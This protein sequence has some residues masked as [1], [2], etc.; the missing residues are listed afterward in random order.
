MDEQTVTYTQDDLNAEIGRKVAEFKRQ[1]SD[2]D[3]L[4]AKIAEY[5]A[6]QSAGEG[7]KDPVADVTAEYE[8]KMQ[9]I[10]DEIEA[11]K[12]SFKPEEP[13]PKPKPIGEPTNNYSQPD[14]STDQLLR[15]AAARAKQTGSQ[16]DIVAYGKL[17]KQLK[18]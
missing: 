16:S 9:S 1:Y 8:A 11:L 5:E 3:E 12:T 10:R 15:D 7:K 14:K 18:R 13:K 17:K 2:Y 6:T 4:K